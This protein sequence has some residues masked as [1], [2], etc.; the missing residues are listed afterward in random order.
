MPC[1]NACPNDFLFGNTI[2][3][4]HIQKRLANALYSTPQ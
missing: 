3:L 1:Y 4:K 2:L